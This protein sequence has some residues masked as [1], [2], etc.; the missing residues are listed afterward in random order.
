MK[1]EKL[2]LKPKKMKKVNRK[3]LH[4]LLDAVLDIQETK[5]LVAWFDLAGHVDWVGVRTALKEDCSEK[6]CS[7]DFV[8]IYG[9]DEMFDKTIREYR[10]N[11]NDKEFRRKK[12][13]ELEEKEKAQLEKL[14]AK[15]EK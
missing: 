10:E 5:G 4:E 13:E 7:Y 9:D 11:S 6:I 15:Y 12:K 3:K 8:N 2:N 14:K 1:I